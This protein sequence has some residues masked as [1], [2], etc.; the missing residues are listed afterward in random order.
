MSVNL[1][2]RHFLKLLDYTAEEIHY[3]LGMARQL[4]QDKQQGIEQPKLSGRNIALIFEKARPE[5]AVLLRSQH[6]IRA[7]VSLT[8]DLPDL[9]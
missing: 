3:L 2:Q 8:W 5:P 9:R 1:K 4:K 7:P 6:S